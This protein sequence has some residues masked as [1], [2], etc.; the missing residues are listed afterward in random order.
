MTL[1]RPKSAPPAVSPPLTETL[2]DALAH[3][4]DGATVMELAIALR[5]PY[6][7]VAQEMEELQHL[8]VV[9]RRRHR[10]STIWVLG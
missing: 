3:H 4:V 7:L 5:V 8:G 1:P 9:V 10:S 2:V 6:P